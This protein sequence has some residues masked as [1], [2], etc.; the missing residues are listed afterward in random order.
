MQLKTQVK[1][2]PSKPGVYF[3]RN[4]NKKVLYIGKAK[5][6]KARVK[7]Y[8]GKKNKRAKAQLITSKATTI[9]Y[10]IVNDEVEALIT[11]S[12][13]IKE[14]KPKYNVSL[15]DDK[16]FPYIIVTKEPYPRVEIIRKKRLN[17]D[18][19]LY[20]GPYTDVKHLRE[21]L[22]AIYNIFPIRT[23]KYN[24]KN[25]LIDKKSSCF[26]GFCVLEESITEEEYNEII[27]QVI[28]FLKG[29]SSAIKEQIKISMERAGSSLKFEQAAKYRD[30][31]IAIDLFMKRQKKIAHD[32]NSYDIVHTS[33]DGGWGVGVVMRV[34]NGLLIGKEKLELKNT[35]ND[36]TENLKGFITQYYSST[37]DIPEKVLVNTAIGERSL[38]EKWLSSKKEKKASII[39]PKIGSKR[40]MLNLC[41]KNTDMELKKLMLQ[42]IKRPGYTSKAL[43]DLKKALS[44]NVT[45]TRIEAFDN[46]NLN[47]KNPVSGLVCF[48]NGKPVKSKYRRFNI[49][50]V[51][52]IDDFKSMEEVVFRR[53]KKQTKE[54]RPLPDLILIDGGKGQLSAAKKTLDG[55]GLNQVVVIGLAKRLEE[56][57]IPG[58]SEAQNISK[59]SP[60]LYLLRQIRDE[61]HRYAISFHRKKR[62]KSAFSSILL[63]IPGLGSKRYAKLINRYKTIQKIKKESPEKINS[64]IKIPIKICKEIFRRLKT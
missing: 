45:P 6:L 14:Y 37:L 41:I 40:K 43:K 54:K 7:S 2:I 9:D 8:F 31:I 33:L 13:M 35:Y 59:T 21:T 53:Y 52:G 58:K 10:L 55:L 22:K 57:F 64:E 11:E 16:T 48:I 24:T 25:N 30:Q 18:G 50:T 47:G 34:R 49:K 44:L 61:V 5:N 62:S 51:K 63:E 28:G 12:N 46:S 23:C 19:N 32:F 15:R 17:K 3:F 20:F 42:K 60:A 36:F 1:N 4:K 38:L 27:K 56:V 26:C 39:H 29:K